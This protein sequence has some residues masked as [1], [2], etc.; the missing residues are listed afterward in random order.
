MPPPSAGDGHRVGTCATMKTY[1]DSSIP[2]ITSATALRDP[3][4]AVLPTA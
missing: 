1:I 2:R 3:T 4:P